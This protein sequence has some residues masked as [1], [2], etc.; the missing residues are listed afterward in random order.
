MVTKRT[1]I[2]R[3]MATPQIKEQAVAIYE[4]MRKL[5]CSC[6]PYPNPKQWWGRE[7]CSGC[8]RW[9]DLHN[10]LAHHIPHRPWEWPLAAPITKYP[11]YDHGLKRY[12]TEIRRPPARERERA[13]ERA[14]REA[15][16]EMRATQRANEATT[17]VNSAGRGQPKDDPELEHPA[18]SPTT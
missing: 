13:L 15:T 4:R 16:R 17:D 3:Q 6:G 1:P 7:E 8:R 9:W 18:E 11:V 2:A 12:T 10:E 14:L 5:R